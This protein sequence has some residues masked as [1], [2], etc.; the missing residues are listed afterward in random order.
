MSLSPVT[1]PAPNNTYAPT[2]HLEKKLNKIDIHQYISHN[3]NNNRNNFNYT[4]LGIGTPCV[5]LVYNVEDLVLNKLGFS[6][7]SWNPIADKEIFCSHLSTLDSVNCQ[8]TEKSG[9]CA[10][11]T[12]KV[13]ASLGNQTA[14]LGKFGNHPS[15]DTYFEMAKQFGITLLAYFSQDPIMR[16]ASL[17]TT[18][19][20]RTFFSNTT[21]ST[22][23]SATK[24]LHPCL[25]QGVHV[26]Y[27]DGF[28]MNE[29][30]TSFVQQAME[31]ASHAGTIIGFDLGSV[32]IVNNN[33]DKILTLLKN[34]VTIV[35]ANETEALALFPGRS[36][37]EIASTLSSCYNCTAV[38]MRGDQG[39]YVS[40]KKNNKIISFSSNAFDIGKP[41]DTTG[42]GDAFIGGWFHAY[43]QGCS[44]ETCAKMGNLLGGTCVTLDGAE[45]PL[46]IVEGLKDQVDS[47]VTSDKASRL[48]ER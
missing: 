35:F 12:I 42:A 45:I 2:V 28:T 30:D 20:Q 43:L 24:D 38:I 19:A 32:G 25:F 31:L 8:K 40:G 14:F 41:K 22:D 33:R 11:N 39:A 1:H 6:K 23:L 15:F 37:E 27:F 34:Y 17:V 4:V 13:L 47:L 26:A 48:R 16:V 46:K 36:Y 21:L 5:D 3:N 9:G 10:S 44:L 7:S 29:F 18:D